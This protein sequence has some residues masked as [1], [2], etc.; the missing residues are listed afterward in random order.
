MSK[1]QI[2]KKNTK[3]EP[4]RTKKEKRAAK[5]AKKNEKQNQGL[6]NE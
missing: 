6:I 5:I 3:K 1:G 2:S 4:A